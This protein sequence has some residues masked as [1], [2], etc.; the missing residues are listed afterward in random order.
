MNKEF[1]IKKLNF[2][3]VTDRIGE[4]VFELDDIDTLTKIHNLICQSKIHYD[5]EE[6]C[7]I[8]E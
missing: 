3:D 5:R 2:E 1:E 4:A 8:E 6:E 7:W